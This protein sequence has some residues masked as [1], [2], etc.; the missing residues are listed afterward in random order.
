MALQ[1]LPAHKKNFEAWLEPEFEAARP[2]MRR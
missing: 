2:Q 1:R